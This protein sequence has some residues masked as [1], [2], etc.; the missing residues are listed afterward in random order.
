[1]PAESPGAGPPAERLTDFVEPV[2][3]H[4][5]AMDRD[6]DRIQDHLE[7]RVGQTHGSDEN[8][9]VPVVVTLRSPVSDQDLADFQTLGGQIDYVYEYVTYGFAGSIP[10]SRLSRFVDQAGARLSMIE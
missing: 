3:Y 9:V 7:T 10:A 4:A 5:Q 6:S 1:M 2:I 8:A